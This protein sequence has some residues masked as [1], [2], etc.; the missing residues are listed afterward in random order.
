MK[1]K[2]NISMAVLMF[3]SFLLAGCGSFWTG[4]GTG[5]VGAGAA[6]EIN[7]KRQL[8]QL[9]QEYKDGKITQAEYESRKE[10]ISKGSL[11]Y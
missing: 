9:E 3:A 6:Y 4:A 5:V 1:I 7:A 8:N 10:Q 11:I 2:K